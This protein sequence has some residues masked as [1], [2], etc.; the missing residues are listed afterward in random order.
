MGPNQ[1]VVMATSFFK[2]LTINIYL[3]IYKNKNVLNLE[4]LDILYILT[5]IYNKSQVNNIFC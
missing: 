5:D 1:I 4:I 2:N 3:M